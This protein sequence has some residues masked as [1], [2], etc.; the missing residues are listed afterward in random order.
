MTYAANFD[1]STSESRSES[2]LR[3]TRAAGFVLRRL[4]RTDEDLLKA[5]REL[6]A[7]GSA[8]SHSSSLHRAIHKP[9]ADVALSTGISINELE[10][11]VTKQLL[12]VLAFAKL[13]SGNVEEHIGAVADLIRT[14]RVELFTS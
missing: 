8:P 10:P 5:L 6:Q 1:L 7:Y 12:E 9:L 2:R 4:S 11:I 13:D 14:G 3:V